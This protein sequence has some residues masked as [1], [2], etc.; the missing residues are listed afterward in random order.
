MH[1]INGLPILL[2]ILSL[3]VY[4]PLRYLIIQKKK[5]TLRIYHE[6]T[7]ILMIIYIESLLYLTVFPTHHPIPN[8]S[9][10]INL[11]PFQTIAMYVEFEGN[12]DIQII[13]LLGNIIV[14]VPIGIFAVILKK[15]ILFREVLIIGFA[16]TC[17]I[18]ITQL[19]FTSIGIIYRSF[20]I[21][22]I[23]LNTIGVLIGYF[24]A[25]SSQKFI[26]FRKS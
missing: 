3:V 2:I 16:S 4:L 25:R 9:V 24:M 14:F 5:E 20:D 18:E 26:P 22:D 10:S 1:Y 13:N 23:I 12:V 21:D 7:Y 6:I 15:K 8:E 17:F 11:I 19:M